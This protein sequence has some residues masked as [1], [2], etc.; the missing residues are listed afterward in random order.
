MPWGTWAIFSPIEFAPAQPDRNIL[1]EDKQMCL[2]KYELRHIIRVKHPSIGS[3]L[4]SV[5]QIWDLTDLLWATSHRSICPH[6]RPAERSRH[7]PLALSYSCSLLWALWKVSGVEFNSTTKYSW[8]SKIP[9]SVETRSRLFRGSPIIY[10]ESWTSF[11]HQF[12]LTWLHWLPQGD[13]AG[14]SRLWHSLYPAIWCLSHK[15]SPLSCNQPSGCN[16]HHQLMIPR[17]IVE[18][19]CLFLTMW[20]PQHIT[21]WVLNI[22][23]SWTDMQIWWFLLTAKLATL[24]SNNLRSMK[25][26]EELPATKI[27]NTISTLQNRCRWH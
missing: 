25:I 10:D 14:R 17:S 7:Q 2:I 9:I 20:M 19:C 8:K 26:G 6:C 11:M 22:S 21:L 18:K 16:T 13:A 23:I 27:F 3:F 5:T 12:I 15:K 4:W 24:S 1:R